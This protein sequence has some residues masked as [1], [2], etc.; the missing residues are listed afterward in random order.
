MKKRIC[1]LVVLYCLDP[2]KSITLKCL[3]SQRSSDFKLYIWDN[4]PIGLTDAQE[5]SLSK[6]F[7]SVEYINTP[8][9]LGL[10]II[11][12]RIISNLNVENDLLV[13][14]D[15]DSY[16]SKE[17]I[18]KVHDYS[19][20]YP[21][22]PVLIPIIHLESGVYHS[23]KPDIPFVRRFFKF[24]G[25][26]VYGYKYR[27]NS[28]NSGNVLNIRALANAGF[29][30]DEVLMFYGVDNSLFRYLY[31]NRYPVFVIPEVLVQSLAINEIRDCEILIAR[32]ESIVSAI[33]AVYFRGGFN[34]WSVITCFHVL[35]VA[36]RKRSFSYLRLINIILK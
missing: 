24:S 29:K 22:I 15:Q 19:A 1:I 33:K 26:R 11:Y 3:K 2:T 31:Q 13:T 23:P 14:F 21:A 32:Y 6:S 27:I 10:S 5:D 4:S 25:G 28:L 7:P 17:Y 16:I 18:S 35:G 34:I 20:E 30:F 12:N 9:N 36:I 8:E